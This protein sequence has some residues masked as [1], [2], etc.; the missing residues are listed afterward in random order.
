[1][2]G[3]TYQS[4]SKACAVPPYFTEIQDDTWIGRDVLICP[5]RK[6][7]KGAVVAA[8]SV[9]TKNVPE[10]TVV[11]GNPARIIKQYDFTKQ[12]WIKPLDGKK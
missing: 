9:V 11:G 1:M 6:I 7:G 5:S 4:G 10:Y 12:Q 3:L 8:R 2:N